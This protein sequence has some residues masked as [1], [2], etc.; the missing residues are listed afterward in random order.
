MSSVYH[1]AQAIL[2]EESPL[3]VYTRCRAH[4]LNFATV[5][6]CDQHVIREYARKTQVK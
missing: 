1:S 4:C 2:L 6:S 3:A 5:H